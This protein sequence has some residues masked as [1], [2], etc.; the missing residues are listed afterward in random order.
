MAFSDWS[1]LDAASSLSS[2]EMRFGRADQRLLDFA[3]ELLGFLDEARAFLETATRPFEHGLDF[4]EACGKCLF[5]HV[6]ASFPLVTLT[7][8]P[9]RMRSDRP[10]SGAFRIA[11]VVG[12]LSTTRVS[13]IAGGRAGTDLSAVAAGLLEQ[14]HLAVAARSRAAEQSVDCLLLS[15]LRSQRGG[16]GDR[17]GQRVI[18]RNDQRRVARD[19]EFVRSSSACR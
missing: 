5:S 14:V 3:H 6:S 15:V 16:A 13:G 1:S 17:R 18:G 4:H 19:L 12:P 8:G 7:A 10:A 9:A 2:G 11:I